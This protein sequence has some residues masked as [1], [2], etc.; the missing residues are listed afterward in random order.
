MM[1]Y[2]RQSRDSRSR[3]RS[4]YEG[5]RR[6]LS[7]SR[8]RSRSRSEESVDVENPGN[9]LYVTG[10]S[11]RITKRE[12]EKHFASEGGKLLSSQQTNNHAST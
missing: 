2:S 4:R 12:L 10:L 6:S 5:D 8:S 7:G 1:S 11:P 9:N 3:S